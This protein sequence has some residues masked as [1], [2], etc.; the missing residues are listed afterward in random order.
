MLSSAYFIPGVTRPAQAIFNSYFS[1]FII[2]VDLGQ[3]IDWRI[4]LVLTQHT[5]NVAQKMSCL[6]EH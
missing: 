3:S 5:P 2:I 4:Y 1:E 6:S